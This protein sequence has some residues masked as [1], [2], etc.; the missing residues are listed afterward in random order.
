MTMLPTT[1]PSKRL[2][3]SITAASTTIQLNNIQGW[4]GNDL[5]SSDFGTRLFAVLR[6]DTNTA[7]E[8][9]ELDPST[10]ASSSITILARGLKF[11]GDLSTEVTANKLS[12]VK[13][14]TIV[15]LGTH[16]PQ[17]L[18]H[19]VQIIGAQTIAGVKTFSSLPATTAGD[20]VGDNDLVRKAQLDAATLGQIGTD[21]LIVSGNAGETIADGELV[22][23]DAVTNNEWMKCDA[24]TA[25]SVDNV[26]LGIAQGAGTD[27]NA[28]S[29][30]ILLFGVDDAQSGMTAG[31]P[32]YT[33]NTAGA[34][35]SSA[36]TTEVTV[37][38]AK[39]AT[40]LYFYPRY[41]QEITE[42]IQDALTGTSGTPSASN[43]YVTADDASAAAA[44]G[45]I[46]R[47]TGTSLPALGG[48]NLVNGLF[49]YAFTAGEAID[50]SSTPQA[51]YLKA[52][53]GKVYK[54]DADAGGEETFA[55]IGFTTDNVSTDESVTVIVA[56]IVGGF[57]GLTAGDTMFLS[58]TAGAVA[59]SEGTIP[60]SV[61]F[62]VSTTQIQILHGSKVYKGQ[63]S[64]SLAADTT[65]ATEDVEITCGFRPKLIMGVLAIA[66]SAPDDSDILNST[67]T[68]VQ[69]FV[70]WTAQDGHR[71][72][73]FNSISDTNSDLT[74]AFG[75][76][77][78]TN[79]P[80]QSGQL[81]VQSVGQRSVTFR[82][83][84]VSGSGA[85][86]AYYE[87]RYIIIG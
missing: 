12:W 65:T 56:G 1:V 45:K 79:S 86:T 81:A 64:D 46:V 22:Y 43:K 3:A 16:V 39:S 83:T 62:A 21:K 54:T 37:G 40:E 55:F 69:T 48:E 47:A 24:D 50:G 23:F 6:N 78:Y 18:N 76:H 66:G 14:E 68:E 82:M 36:G 10:I 27:G 58:D 28:I 71:G 42:D 44:S 51:V 31:D 13:N 29:G 2:A 33:S 67:N 7:M 59:N 70:E 84:T 74:S 15:E 4:D 19:M 25:A 34:I 20:A 57:T 87:F 38:I 26:I 72:Y 32:M 77:Q 85:T 49:N 73:S 17:L 35:A 41:N 63:F 11:T 75:K 30:G 60:Y 53:D 61:G 5:T 80:T 8:I 52:S 9:V